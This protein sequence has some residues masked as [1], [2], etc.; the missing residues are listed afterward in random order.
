MYAMMLMRYDISHAVRVVNK[1]IA[2]LRRKHWKAVKWIMRYLS[3][4][5]SYGLVYGKKNKGKCEGLLGYMDSNYAEDLDKRRSLTSYI[6]IFNGCLINWKV[7]RQHGVA[8]STTTTK[9]IVATEAVKEALWLQGLMGELGVK[10][11]I[12]T[13]LYCSSSA[14][15]MCRNLIHHERTKHIDIKLHF[16]RNEVFK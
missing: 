4:T 5:L 10:Q 13:V 15:H 6:F 3:G 8:L 16:I 11:K 2:S 9:Y 12:V 1:Y 7:T 14:L